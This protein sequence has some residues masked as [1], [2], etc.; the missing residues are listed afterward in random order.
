ANGTFTGTATHAAAGEYEVT[1]QVTDNKTGGTVT[2]TLT[3]TVT[4]TDT[5]PT[6]A[7]I[8]DQTNAENQTVSLAVTGA[9]TDGDTLT[10]SATGLPGGLSIDPATGA[11]T[12]TLTFFSAGTH[13]VTVTA[14]D[15]ANNQ[16]ARTFTWRV[17]ETLGAALLQGTITNQATGAPLAGASVEVVQLTGGTSVR[18]ASGTNGAYSTG[19]PEGTFKVRVTLPG[20]QPYETSISFAPGQVQVLNA[21]LVPLTGSI[22][23]LILT[24][25]G[26]AVADLGVYLIDANG[27]QVAMARS[28]DAGR[29]LFD[30]VSAGAYKLLTPNP[31][32]PLAQAEVTVQPNLRADVTLRLPGKATLSLTAEPPSIVGDG[33]STSTLLAAL[34]LRDGTPLS[35]TTVRFIATAGSLST[36]ATST[37]ADGRASAV[38]TAP[39]IEGTQ[40][41]T[42]QVRV[43]VRDEAQGIF[44]DAVITV[45]FLPAS[46]HG[47]VTDGAT[48]KPVAGALVEIAEDFD[49]NGTIDFRATV[50]TGPDGRYAIA[51]PRGNWNYKVQT[52]APMT[53]GGKTIQVKS[54]QNSQ[55]GRLQGI[56]ETIQASRTVGGQ[57]LVVGKSENGAQPAGEVLKQGEQ[58][59]G[60]V[61][62]SSG[63]P[64]DLDVTIHEDG[65]FEVNDVEPGE[66]QVVFQVVA[67][68]GE[69]LA[70]I[71]MNIVVNQEGELALN[72]GLIDP[73]G[74]V[75]DAVTGKPVE[76]VT[77]NLMWADTP[78]NRSKG[79]LPDTMVSLP[80]LPDFAPN[81]NRVPQVTTAAG[82]Y[83]WMVWPDG[84]YYIVAQRDGYV[85]YDSRKEGRNVPA[86]PGEDGYVLNGV[87]HVGTTIVEYDLSLTPV[88]KAPGTPGTGGTTGPGTQPQENQPAP[89]PV[90]VPTKPVRPAAGTH[91][92]YILGYPDGTFGPERSITRAEVATVLARILE[93]DYTDT[94]NPGFTDT[95]DGAWYNGYVNAIRKSG[96]MIGYPDGSFGPNAPITR[97]EIATVLARL[98]GLS[99]AAEAA[100]AD[101]IGHWSQQ[102]V[103][104]VRKEGIMNGYPDGTFK[105]QQNMTRA[106]F[107]TAI[108]RL[109]NRGPLTDRPGQRFPDVSLQHWAHGHVEEASIHHSFESMI[110]REHWIEDVK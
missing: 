8:P 31:T 89:V 47:V 30:D 38:L 110:D 1:I 108:N 17:T 86:G 100:F 7:L 98:R 102:Y 87:I 71:K 109:W 22:A 75:T 85:T 44:A 3:I 42:E 59:Q 23:G 80:V 79:R 64:L 13:T 74:V 36:S 107:V 92:P 32:A 24:E 28:D 9:D 15:P 12:G 96:I 18:A 56:G 21:A 67:P 6:L 91:K 69:K 39:Q 84:D 16:A 94:K 51:V 10:Y 57:I 26:F 101:T 65:T 77:M 37:G 52:T 55:V 106:E 83:A 81:Q 95:V 40:P 61:L 58:I 43:T 54:S 73:Y 97:A 76:G 27:E 48:G 103:S 33:R 78:L 14:K 53:V 5:V 93:L 70:G 50:T 62:S 45:T 19:V 99:L 60:S 20:Y 104:A 63:E 66:Y 34:Q 25:G 105:P 49:G 29:F 88:G 82:E 72:T 68:S 35:G 90:L 11:I 4:N 46:I 2:Q 41:R